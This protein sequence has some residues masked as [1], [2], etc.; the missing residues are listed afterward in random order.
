MIVF[1]NAI[2]N[3]RNRQKKKQRKHIGSLFTYP[4]IKYD[5]V[6]IGDGI[7]D[8]ETYIKHVDSLSPDITCY[9]E[10]LNTEQ[11]FALNFARLHD[12]PWT[13]FRGDK[14]FPCSKH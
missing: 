4:G 13:W 12:F 9:C 1:G 3:C 8:Y 14:S 11:D 10:H 5:E 2:E 6:F 7:I